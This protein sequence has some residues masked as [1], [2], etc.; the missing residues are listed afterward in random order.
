MVSGFEDKDK[1][2]KHL[3]RGCE[4]PL[5]EMFGFKEIVSMDSRF[6]GNDGEEGENTV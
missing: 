6:R 5:P 4:N 1:N 3:A 2:K